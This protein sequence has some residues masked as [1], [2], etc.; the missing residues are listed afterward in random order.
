VPGAATA[1]CTTRIRQP[2]AVEEGALVFVVENGMHGGLVMP[3]RHG[4][5]VQYDY[6]D[7]NYYARDRKGAWTA[8]SSLFLPSAGT[9]ARREV[10]GHMH[11]PDEVCR[12]LQADKALPLVVERARVDALLA[13][14]DRRFD[15]RRPTYL[16][17]PV[18]DT[19]FVHDPDAYSVFRT[20]NHILDGWLRRLDCRTEGW[21]WT[22][23]FVLAPEDESVR[24]RLLA[25]LANG[26]GGIV[27]GL[28]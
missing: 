2:T 8:V 16:Y 3:T 11:D 18:L 17:D 1:S 10:P 27:N 4:T 19:G 7:W 15:A 26:S 5:T 20:C 22:W 9:L 23:D 6:G 25:R 13:G 12:R 24:S 14:L 28:E 21:Y